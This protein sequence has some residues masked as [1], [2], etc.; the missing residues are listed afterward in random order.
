MR[1]TIIG[2]LGSRPAS[3]VL[4]LLKVASLL[5]ILAL[6]VG[7]VGGVNPWQQGDGIIKQPAEKDTGDGTTSG[8]PRGQPAATPSLSPTA[9]TEKR[10]VVLVHL[11]S[12]RAQSTSPYDSEMKTTPFLEELAK[13]S[14]LAEHAYTIVPHTSKASVAVNC[15]IEPNI[16]QEDAEAKPGGIPVPCLASL[17]KDQGYR[18]VFFQSPSKDVD[19]FEGLVK[20]FGYAEYYPLESMST[21]S[22]KKVNA[23]SYEDDIMLGP[24][25]AWLREHK[26]KAFVAEYRTG[27]GYH[28]YQCLGLRYGDK[29][30]SADDATNRYLNCLRLQDFF[31][32]NL[33]DQ[34]KE[35]GLYEHTIFVIFGDH[36]EGFGE[37]ERYQHDDTIYE[38]GL[39][40]PLLIH[41]PGWFSSGERVTGLANVTD[42]LPT[43]LEMLGFEVQN[44]TYTG[45]S[46]LHALPEDRTL[47]FSCLHKNT[48]LASIKGARKYIYHYDNQPDELFDLSED[49]LEEHNLAN[50]GG[51]EGTNQQEV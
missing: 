48:C 30:F 1:L 13:T 18:T 17:L 23:F 44:G 50:E 45:Y 24:S 39:K 21:D 27:A 38:E 11:E 7:C 19:D 5:L 29:T 31:V 49:P 26:D 42:I 34:Y 25:A 9:Q 43:V 6:A 32:K 14:L 12:T 33:I 16:A 51:T 4:A 28:D 37:H 47:M 2:R 8:P 36:G 20:N 35:V 41:A 40:V 10:N 3:L 46:L 15:G 22:L